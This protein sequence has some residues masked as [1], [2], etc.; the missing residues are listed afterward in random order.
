MNLNIAAGASLDMRGNSVVVNQLSGDGTVYSSNG[1][2]S[3]TVG[4]RGEVPPSAARYKA[5]TP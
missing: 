1:A 5:R 4:R 3:L 2:Y